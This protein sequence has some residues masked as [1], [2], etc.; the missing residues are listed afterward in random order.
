MNQVSHSNENNNLADEGVNRDSKTPKTARGAKTK[1]KILSAAAIEFG[2]RGY[3]DCQIGDITRR[4]SVGMGTFYIYFTTKEAIFRELVSYMGHLTRQHIAQNI[5]G[6]KSR[7]DAEKRGLRAF[8]EFAREHKD[9]Y[10]IVMESQFVAPDA[11]TQYYSVFQKAYANQLTAA[12]IK[13]EISE[14]DNQI[15]AWSLI[16]LSVFLGMR[17]G[18][19]D[20]AE[21]IDSITEA[22]F[23]LIENGLSPRANTKK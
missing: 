18:I 22:G 3:H 16:G 12:Q 1:S 17:F 23:D 21:D 14:G 9:L 6:A 2:A 4:A 10:R 8:I 11:Y 5:N 13:G 15:R 7:L 20:D 19:W